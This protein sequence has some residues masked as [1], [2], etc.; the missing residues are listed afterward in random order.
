MGIKTI[1]KNLSKAQIASGIATFIDYLVLIILVEIVRIWPII[2]TGFGSL[3]GAIV[4]FKVSQS[5]VFYAQGKD[6]KNQIIRYAMVSAGSVLLNS[7]GMY[8]FNHVFLFNYLT[9]KIIISL[10][11]GLAY[12]F[13]FHHFFVFKK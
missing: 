8:I 4:H 7:L 1:V 6:I 5:W 10:F 13:T 11:V 3:A 12:N 9:S 2:A